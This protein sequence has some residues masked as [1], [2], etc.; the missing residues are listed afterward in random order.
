[1]RGVESKAGEMSWRAPKND[2]VQINDRESGFGKGEGEGG[3]A[4]KHQQ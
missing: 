2:D 4:K 3:K 1:M